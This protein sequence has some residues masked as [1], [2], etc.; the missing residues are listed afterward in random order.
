LS[1]TSLGGILRVL[2]SERSIDAASKRLSSGNPFS[3]ASPPLSVETA[4]LAPLRSHVPP[5][6]QFS[7]FVPIAYSSPDYSIPST[8]SRRTRFSP[9]QLLS[10]L[11]VVV[12]F[13][14][15]VFRSPTDTITRPFESTSYTESQPA[16]PPPVCRDRI[17]FLEP[18]PVSRANEMSLLEEAK[19]VAAEFE[20]SSEDLNKG[21]KAFISQMRRWTRLQTIQ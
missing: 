15:Q 20:Y 13:A 1:G 14:V 3:P 6:L 2:A 21:V 11:V 8:L 12:V 9:A 7:S 10:F 4:T 16:L 17:P 18:L 19:R 5:F